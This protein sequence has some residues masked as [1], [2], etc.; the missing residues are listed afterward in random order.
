MKHVQIDNKCE[1]LYVVRVI[2]EI[3]RKGIFC[4]T[5]YT[6]I[7]TVRKIHKPAKQNSFTIF[8]VYSLLSIGHLTFKYTLLILY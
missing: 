7:F 6:S 3:T 4:V 1:N 8:T 2:R 5:S